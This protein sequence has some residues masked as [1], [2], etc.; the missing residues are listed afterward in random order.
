[1]KQRFVEV[2][3]GLAALSASTG[4]LQAGNVDIPNGSFESPTAP[5]VDLNVDSW[6]K[7]PKPDWY[8]EGGGFLWSQ[9]TGTFKNTPAGSVDHIENCDGNQAI[10]MFAIP[11]AGLFQD[12]HSM[13]WNDSAPS[14]EFNAKFEV[15]S[16]YQLT[17]GVIAGGGGMSNG[18]TAEISLYYRDA[19]SN[20]VTV[21]AASITNTPAVFRDRTH[22]VDFSAHVPSVKAGDAWANQNIGIQLLSTVGASLQGG[23]WDFDNVRLASSEEPTVKLVF[24]PEGSDLRISWLSALNRQ[25]QVQVSEHLSSWSDFDSPLIGTGEELSKLVPTASRVKTFV[26]VLAQLSP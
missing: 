6:Q 7:S 16:S 24:A 8:V 14:H 11:E 25:Y 12:F 5:F 21:A 26:R 13:D 17:V 9:L 3:A 19:A 23:Y 10:W 2:F 18:V 22:L 15:H 1:M 20:R 4:L